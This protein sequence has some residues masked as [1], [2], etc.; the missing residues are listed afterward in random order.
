MKKL[1]DP[2]EGQTLPEEVLASERISNSVVTPF[3]W[4]EIVQT[5]Q[6]PIAPAE[7]ISVQIVQRNIKPTHQFTEPFDAKDLTKTCPQNHLLE[8]GTSVVTLDPGTNEIKSNNLCDF[9]G[10]EELYSKSAPN[11]LYWRCTG[12]EGKPSSF[13]GVCKN[14]YTSHF[15][16]RK[17]EAKTSLHH[18]YEN[19][20]ITPNTE[21]VKNSR[22]ALERAIASQNL[23]DLEDETANLTSQD[24]IGINSFATCTMEEPSANDGKDVSVYAFIGLWRG[25]P[26]E[27]VCYR[28]FRVDN[29]IFLTKHKNFSDDLHM[30][31]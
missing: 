28:N 27:M 16:R 11:N 4:S 9:C 8:Y 30:H 13:D 24:D 22:E 12:C 14:C 15:V 29:P 6:N 23:G 10:S 17:L 25:K 31:A 21:N 3:D 7:I 19:Y 2:G 1:T 5:L 26:E 20:K 18:S